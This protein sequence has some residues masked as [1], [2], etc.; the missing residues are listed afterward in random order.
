MKIAALYDDEVMFFRQGDTVRSHDGDESCV[1]IG[2]WR[3]LLWLDP[4]DYGDG[5]P[6]TGRARDYELVRRAYA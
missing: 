3:D 5:A 1:I 4:I 2:I 6:F